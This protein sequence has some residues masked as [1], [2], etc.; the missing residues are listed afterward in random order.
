MVKTGCQCDLDMKTCWGCDEPAQQAVWRDLDEDDYYSCPV[1]FI[2]EHVVAWYSEY[3]YYLEF[4]SAPAYDKLPAK[5]HEAL[6]V[7]KKALAD[8]T[9]ANK[10]RGPDRQAPLKQAVRGRKKHG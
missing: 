5:W 4:G 8:Y 6:G 3:A 9:E 7:Y 10:P 2:T 1:K